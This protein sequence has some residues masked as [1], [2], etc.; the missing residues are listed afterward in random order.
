MGVIPQLIGFARTE[1]LN[2]STLTFDWRGV[3][4]VFYFYFYGECGMSG[5]TQKIKVIFY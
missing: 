3:E 2:T 1:S 5:T 4:F